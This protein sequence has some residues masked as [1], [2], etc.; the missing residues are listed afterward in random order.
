MRQKGGFLLLFF[1]YENGQ[2]L[3]DCTNDV[4]SCA[5]DGVEHDSRPCH[6]NRT[7]TCWS[8]IRVHWVTGLTFGNLR[9]QNERKTSSPQLRQPRGFIS[10]WVVFES[11]SYTPGARAERDSPSVYVVILIAHARSR[12]SNTPSRIYINRP[13]PWLRSVL[14]DVRRSLRFASG[15]LKSPAA[16]V[17]RGTGS[18]ARRVG[19]GVHA[20]VF[21]TEGLPLLLQCRGA[22]RYYYHVLYMVSPDTGGQV[23]CY[24]SKTTV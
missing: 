21:R 12:V 14:Q 8:V 7:A 20:S 10:T 3:A 5:I 13:E 23:V 6:Q 19:A 16:H 9:K 1:W 15:I 2:G 18:C 4:T 17:W 24:E 11:I 22:G